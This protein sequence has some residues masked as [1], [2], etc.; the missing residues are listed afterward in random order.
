MKQPIENVNIR[1]NGMKKGIHDESARVAHELH[2]KRG[3]IPGNELADWLEAE[4]IVTEK[5]E[6]H[7]RETEQQ[8]DAIEKP[9]EGFRRT[10]KKE[11]FYKKG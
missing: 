9:R 1:E 3:R 4:K 5:H 11:G 7:A 10:V 6:R 2:E 8:V